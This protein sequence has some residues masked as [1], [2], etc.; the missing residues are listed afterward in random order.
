[1]FMEFD[2]NGMHP[3]ILCI[4][5]D[6]KFDG[7]DIHDF[8][9]KIYQVDRKSSKTITFQQLYG[10]IS[11]KYK[12]HP[13]FAKAQSYIDESWRFFEE[14]GFIKCPISGYI[15]EKDKLGE[16]NPQKLLN[17][18][19]QN[20]ETSMNILILYDIFKHIRKLKSKIVLYVY[21][22]ILIDLHLSEKNIIEEIVSNAYSRFNFKLNKKIG[23]NYD[24]LK[25]SP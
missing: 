13:F 19:L 4:L 22:S 3:N 24:D 8:L 1:V 2:I 11:Q 6:Y 17:Y 9:S 12:N 25:V 20:L 16:M 21:D 7:E 5:V 10:G 14:N 18:I 15:F 23:L